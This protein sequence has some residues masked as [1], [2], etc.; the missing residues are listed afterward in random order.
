MDCLGTTSEKRSILTPTCT[1]PSIFLL[2]DGLDQGTGAWGFLTF[3]LSGGIRRLGAA[4][5][6]TW[7]VFCIGTATPALADCIQTGISVTCSGT[8]A[9]GFDAGAQDGLAVTVQPGATVSNP[10][11]IVI[12]LNNNNVVTNLGAISVDP[13]F[14][15]ISGGTGN[16]VTNAGTITGGDSSAGIA[17]LGGT[18]MNSGTITVGANGR[19]RHRRADRHQYEHRQHL[20]RR[21]QQRHPRHRQWRHPDQQRLDRGRGF[22]L[23]HQP[24]HQRQFRQHPEYRQHLRRRRRHRHQRRSSTTTISPSSTA[25]RSPS[26]AAAPASRRPA[27]A[28]PSPTAARSRSRSAAAVAAAWASRPAIPIP[29]RTPATSRSATFGGGITGGSSSTSATAARS[30]PA[31][32]A[33]ASSST[34]TTRRP[35]TAARSSSATRSSLRR[36]HRRHTATICSSPTAGPSVV[37][38]FAFAHGV[39]GGDDG[40]LTNSGTITIGRDGFGNGR[41]GQRQPLHQQRQRSPPDRRR[42]GMFNA[43]DNDSMLQYRHDHRR[44]RRHRHGQRQRQQSDND[45]CRHDRRSATAAPAMG[46]NGDG[47]VMTNRGSIVGRRLRRGHGDAGQRRDTDQQRH[48]QRRRRRHRHGQPGHRRRRLQHR[49]ASRSVPAAS[50]STPRQAAARRSPTAAAS[51]ATGCAATGVSLGDGDT[52]TNSGVIS[53]PFSVT[54]F[55]AV[56]VMNTGTLDGAIELGGPAARSPMPA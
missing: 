1:C 48:D 41:P 26:A 55:G 33:S 56:T 15:G 54:S 9:T 22:R 43:G 10:G 38:R 52:L 23:R 5:L 32:A 42:L 12:T 2:E 29:S 21:H 39:L 13:N 51:S 20:R 45:Q 28:T 6:G 8:S 24:Q 49:A 19:R 16:Q 4:L 30:G 17:I 47:G 25:A 46:H 7:I 18:V 36:R 27:P 50:A 37:G 40:T 35:A 31:T 14:S 11:T 53:A 34:A 44:Q 3:S